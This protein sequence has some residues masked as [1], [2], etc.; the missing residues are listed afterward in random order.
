MN[1]D[2]LVVY[3]IG[4]IIVLALLGAIAKWWWER[5][6][7]QAFRAIAERLGLRFNHH[8]DY[9]LADRLGFLNRLARGS[10]RYAFN[11]IQGVYQDQPVLCFDYHYE[12]YSRSSKG[13]RQTH[14]HYMSVYLLKHPVDFPELEIYPRTLI[15]RIGQALGFSDIQFE[16]V[17]FSKAFVV[18]SAERRFAYDVCH[19]RMMEF[20]L[21][22]SDLNIEIEAHCIA[23]C[24]DRRQKPE[25]VQ[26]HLDTLVQIRE[27]MPGYLYAD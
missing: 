22:H 4:G 23:I 8:R 3:I 26:P 7:R 20:L 16:S 2:T 25:E 9:A 1:D 11:V 18:K 5:R 10:K 14:H 6:R 21:Q 24:Y 15:H 12:T 27:L 13:R 19:P 17:D